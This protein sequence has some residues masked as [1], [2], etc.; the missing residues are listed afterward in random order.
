MKT[1]K[2]GWRGMPL[3]GRVG[4]FWFMDAGYIWRASG[5]SVNQNGVITF[6]GQDTVDIGSPAFVRQF[7]PNGTAK[8]ERILADSGYSSQIAFALASCTANDNHTFVTGYFNSTVRSSFPA[9]IA[10]YNADG[11]LAYGKEIYSSFDFNAQGSGIAVDASGDVIA[12]GWYVSTSPI[13]GTTFK[14]SVWLVKLSGGAKV[15]AKRLLRITNNLFI[16]VYQVA[17]APN[18]IYMTGQ[19]HQAHGYDAFLAKFDTSGALQWVRTIGQSS[20]GERTS[21]ATGLC[22]LNDQ[23]YVSGG[24]NSVDSGVS[25][26]YVIKFSAAGTPIW[27]RQ[28]DFTRAEISDVTTD[29]T[30]LYAIGSDGNTGLGWLGKFDVNGVSDWKREF[31]GTSSSY[32]YNVKFD[33]R[34]LV[35]MHFLQHI[36]KLP[37]DGSRLGTYSITGSTYSIDISESSYALTNSS[38]VVDD[39][40]SE[41]ICD[42]SAETDLIINDRSFYQ[43]STT[44]PHP[45]VRF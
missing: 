30:S 7:N 26:G 39:V 37:T 27:K 12:S 1:S 3:S 41:F 4:A 15:W 32:F 33:G 34:H 20:T 29:G 42:D 31:T 19:I 17:A 40:T 43:R 35:L 5:I 25:L 18:A 8:W 6:A 21:W 9:F 45:I 22:L 13:S 11:S 14:D 2:T 28:L 38:L 36:G 16:D 23:I 24:A 44:H 10:K